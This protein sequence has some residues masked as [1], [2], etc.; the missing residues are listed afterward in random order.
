V[1]PAAGHV[2]GYRVDQTRYE[3]TVVSFLARSIG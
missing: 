2:D 3:Q 1:V